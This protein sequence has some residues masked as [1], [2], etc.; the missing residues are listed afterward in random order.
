MILNETRRYTYIYAYLKNYL[1]KNNNKERV[2]AVPI[3]LMNT[4][5]TKS[6]G[7]FEL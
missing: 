7:F 3:L 2:Q 4:T 5:T 1:Q 6:F